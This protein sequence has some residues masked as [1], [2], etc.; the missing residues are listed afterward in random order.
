MPIHKNNCTKYLA[1][2]QLR[3]LFS[4]HF[5]VIFSVLFKI[6]KRNKFYK[7]FKIAKTI[8]GIKILNK[9]R[10]LEY[11]QYLNFLIQFPPRYFRLAFIHF[12]N[13]ISCSACSVSSNINFGRYTFSNALKD[14]IMSGLVVNIYINLFIINIGN[15]DV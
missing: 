10:M 1:C 3:N 6:T 13:C 7:D 5:T 14:Y 9:I 2:H 15:F 11:L 4:K 8:S 12:L